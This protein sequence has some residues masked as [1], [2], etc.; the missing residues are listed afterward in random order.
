MVTDGAAGSGGHPGGGSTR[1]LAGRYRLETRLGRGGMGVVWRATDE[2]LGRQVAVKEVALD[3]GDELSA[4]EV[5]VQRERA[6]R[7]ARALAQLGHPGIIAV[8]DVVEA[9]GRPYIVMELVDGPSLAE[10][11]ARNGPVDTREAARIGIALLGALR[12]AHASGVLHRDLKPANVLLESETGRVVLTDFG[13]AHLS[14]STTLT[15]SGSFMGSP[16]YTAPERMSGLRSGPESD[17]WSLGALLC[18]AVSGTSPFHRDN[19]GA[20]LHAV[21]S[22]EI[23]TPQEAGPLLP[24]ILG[25]L[26]RDPD[27]RLDAA[28]TERMLRDYADTGRVPEP[29]AASE[30]GEPGAAR[31]R[32][33]PRVA[34][35]PYRASRGA[36]RL[37]GVSRLTH[38]GSRRAAPHPPGSSTTDQP[39]PAPDEALSGSSEHPP[40]A[41]GR[42]AVRPGE[43]PAPGGTGIPAARGTGTSGPRSPGTPDQADRG[44][45]SGAEGGGVRGTG[46]QDSAPPGTAG[47]PAGNDSGPSGA[48]GSGGAGPAAGERQDHTFAPHERPSAPA[49][50]PVPL[51]DRTSAPPRRGPAMPGATPGGDGTASGPTQHP[52]AEDR[53]SP[54]DGPPTDTG[55]WPPPEAEP[56][57]PPAPRGT[58]P[59]RGQPDPAVPGRRAPAAPAPPPSAAHE[60]A[61]P[62][63]STGPR[64]EPSPRRPR[65]NP[66]G[67]ATP[68][69]TRS[70]RGR[71]GGGAGGASTTGTGSADPAGGAPDTSADGEPPAGRGQAPFPGARERTPGTGPG[72]APKAESTRRMRTMLIAIALAAGIAGAGVSAVAL[73]SK[74]GGNGHREPSTSVPATPTPT[75]TPTPSPTRAPTHGSA[76]AAPPSPT[77]KSGEPTP[78]SSGPSASTPP[79]TGSSAHT[80]A[81]TPAGGAFSEPS[82]R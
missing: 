79:R 65:R 22:D 67:A 38:R 34:R 15:E 35:L 16:E 60:T 49:D 1:V 64:P 72:P 3:L 75:P 31:M 74:G 25:L 73:L 10:R 23:R 17:L 61:A 7:E 20:V 69:S 26:E 43:S 8:H 13:T 5:R 18:T 39:P 66:A 54:Q 56:W 46:A 70:R 14:G 53:P 58:R 51:S 59:P 12:K 37:P 2:L 30:S 80:P 21:V 71:T 41:E 55:P 76:P 78:T 77:Q 6:L 33:A 24:V 27:R 11:I 32:W 52:S 57:S 45:P 36:G 50:H 42:A 48:E 62:G 28:E 63:P 81:D 19:L 47:R 29:R 44:E 9:E 40:A 82:S 68:P 4:D